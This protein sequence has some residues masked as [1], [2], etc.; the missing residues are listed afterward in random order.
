MF[1]LY[2]H[3]NRRYESGQLFSDQYVPASVAAGASC[4]ITVIFKPTTLGLET[5]NLSIA[6][7][8]TD[9]PQQVSLSGRGIT[10]ATNL[11]GSA[12]QSALTAQRAVTVPAPMGAQNHRHATRRFGR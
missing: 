8:S 5:A 2:R 11:R 9:S 4:T 1:E 12:A 3:H 7:G 6:D 10:K